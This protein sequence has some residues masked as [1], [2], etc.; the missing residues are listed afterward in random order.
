MMKE[1]GNLPVGIEYQ[2]QTCTQFTLREQI[3]ADAI[4]ILESQDAKRALA[5]DNYY[6]VCVMAKRLKIAGIPEITPAMVMAMNQLDYDEVHKAEQRF[7]Q[8]RLEFRSQ[9]GTGSPD[10]PGP[11]EP[12]ASLGADPGHAGRDG[13]GVSGGSGVGSARA[14]K[15]YQKNQNL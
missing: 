4:E 6:G 8:R 10:P 14:A 13:G 15:E 2:G 1:K 9:G 11:S 12:G 5:S 3:V 7:D